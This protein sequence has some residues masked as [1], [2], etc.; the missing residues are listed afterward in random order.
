MPAML[1]AW[2][3]AQLR[4]PLAI[5]LLAPLALLLSAAGLLSPP[6]AN[7]LAYG[8]IY[9]ILAISLNQ[10]TGYGGQLSFGH[11]ALLGVGGFVTGITV[12]RLAL[13]PGTGLPA[14]LLASMAVGG[15][16][17][18]LVG[19]PALRLRG[20][21][22]AI[23]TFAFADAFENYVF[24]IQE[25]TGLGSG[26]TV[27]RPFV[28]PVQLTASVGML[29]LILVF[30]ALAWLVD[31]RL[32]ATRP[33]RA[34]LA[35]RENESVAASFGVPVAAE[36]LRAFVLSGAIAGLAGCLF[37]YQVTV[38]T[39]SSFTVLASLSFL[40][41]VV[42]GGLGAR[43]GV[44][45]AAVLFTA[46]PQLLVGLAGW[47]TPVLSALLI[48]TLAR[49]PGGLPEQVAHFR[50]R[51]EL[52]RRGLRPQAAGRA[53]APEVDAVS[54]D[55]PEIGDPGP[56]ASS[57][58]V[59]A[60]ADHTVLHLPGA[61]AELRVE[62]VTVNF[63]GLRAVCGAALTV[64]AGAAVGLIGPNGAGKSTLFN[65]ISGFQRPDTGTVHFDGH[66]I[67]RLPAHR[68]A[69]LGIGRTFQQVGLVQ[70]ATVLDNLLL[71]QQPALGYGYV[72]GLAAS[73]RSRREEREARERAL[74]LLHEVGLSAY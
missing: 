5:L 18:L 58:A 8:A 11:A 70:R 21:Y 73:P 7:V 60:S 37:A 71:A 39:K 15:L 72:W 1:T 19:L 17:A 68:R 13:P 29:A 32:L 28:G 46:L 48:V 55:L 56:A 41:I 40:I 54:G 67:T 9:A 59:T 30:L 26:I 47:Q 38:V 35:I 20:V 50:E 49:Y 43:W 23:V 12:N 22:L 64:P 61:A 16:V 74:E 63:R 53:G 33:G 66:E 2:L 45:T 3:P 42:V 62:G 36:K 52:R 31:A 65:V 57:V 25:L 44:V 14:A 24:N 27:P 34:L 4:T 69:R 6:V 51:R 10:L